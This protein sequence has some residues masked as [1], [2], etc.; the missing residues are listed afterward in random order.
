MRK[1]LVQISVLSAVLV[2]WPTPIE[3][4]LVGAGPSGFVLGFLFAFP[5]CSEA[6]QSLRN[7][8]LQ[9]IWAS[10]SFTAEDSAPEGLEL[11]TGHTCGG[12]TLG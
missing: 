7:T 3:S 9:S 4:D 12:Q 8:A 6:P 5:G 11:L 2:G 10:P 1:G